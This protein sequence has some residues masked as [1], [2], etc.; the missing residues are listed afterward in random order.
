MPK[1]VVIGIAGGT[2]SGKT[3]I[4]NIIQKEFKDDVLVVPQDAYYHSFNHLSFEERE[5]INFDHPSSFDNALYLKHIKELKNS[6]PVKIPSYDYATHTRKNTN[7]LVT[8]KKI[9][10][11]EG[12]L[13][14]AHKKLLDEMDIKIYVDTD[15]DIRILRRIERDISERG[16]TLESVINQYRQTVRPMHI[17][18]VEPS[19]RNADVIVPEG[20]NNKIAID[21]ILTKV[22]QILNSKNVE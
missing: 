21:M 4:T 3:T 1:P 22:Q 7:N 11:V 18:F 20:G 6:V 12:I 10:I 2:G 13:I 16:R 17:E 5:K 14:F 19:K 9:I 8:P 15:A